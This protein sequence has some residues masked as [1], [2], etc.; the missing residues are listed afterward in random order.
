MYGDAE[1]VFKWTALCSLRMNSQERP[2]DSGQAGP[3]AGAGMGSLPSPEK[4]AAPALGSGGAGFAQGASKGSVT[5]FSTSLPTQP[6]GPRASVTDTRVNG[7]LPSSR[8]RDTSGAT[9]TPTS[10]LGPSPFP[11]ILDAA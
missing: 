3:R 2:V 10:S 5:L 7:D 8:L 6:L 9:V 11:V 1:A 4:G